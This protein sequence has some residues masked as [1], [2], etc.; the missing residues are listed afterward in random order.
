[1]KLNVSVTGFQ[2]VKFCVVGAIN[3]LIDVLI[4]FLLTRYLGFALGLIFVAKAI[5][6]VL[7][8]LNSFFLNRF[9]TFEKR[10]AF[11]WRKM[12]LFYITVG[13]GIFINV[14][15]HFINVEIL[16][17]NDIFSSLVAAALTALWGFS[18]SKYFIF[19]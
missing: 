14:A 9:W 17:L 5:S 11:E 12:L 4:Y 7:A 6:Y 2:F 16:M 19:R 13:S 10:D 1:M 15:A 3:T 18:W 8:T